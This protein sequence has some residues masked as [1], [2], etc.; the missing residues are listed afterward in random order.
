MRPP[1]QPDVEALVSFLPSE[2]GGRRNGALSG[3]R[4]CHLVRPDYLTSGQHEY[5][6]KAVV[7]PGESAETEIWF[8]APEQ[9]PHCLAVGDD[10]R[11]QEGS[12][13]VGHAKI[14]KIYN[15]LLTRI[16]VQNKSCE[17]N[18]PDDNC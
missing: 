3:Y 6:S 4:P 5:K 1:R 7:M 8:L 18:H 15:T 10:I 16:E 13:L 14:L 2:Q 17:E 9:Y 12:R 11:I